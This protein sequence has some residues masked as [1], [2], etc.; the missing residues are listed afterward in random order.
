MAKQMNPLCSSIIFHMQPGYMPVRIWAFKQKSLAL[1]NFLDKESI[2][3]IDPNTGGMLFQI[4]AVFFGTISGFVLLFSGRIRMMI[5][6]FRR[7]RRGENTEEA[8]NIEDSQTS[9]K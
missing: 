8:K 3:Y 5:A 1:K 6:Q 7:G 4:L 2:M 9:T